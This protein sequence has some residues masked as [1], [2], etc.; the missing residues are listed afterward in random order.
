MLGKMKVVE[1]LKDE[2]AV[3][4]KG[5]EVLRDCMCWRDGSAGENGGIGGIE[6]GR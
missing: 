1:R 3:C 4:V 5:V 2:E 6:G